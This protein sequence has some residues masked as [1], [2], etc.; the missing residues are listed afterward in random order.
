[1]FVAKARWSEAR[2]GLETALVWMSRSGRGPLQCAAHLALL[3]PYETLDLAE[4]VERDRFTDVDAIWS[5]E[6]ALNVGRALGDERRVKEA[7]HLLDLL[8]EYQKY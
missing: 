8:I 3:A 2:E 6:Q 7:Q 5:A 4:A 1:M